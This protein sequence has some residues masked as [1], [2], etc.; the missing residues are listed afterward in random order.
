MGEE[1]VK[2]R[3]QG[4]RGFSEAGVVEKI[5]C[6]PLGNMQKSEL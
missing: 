1:R 3:S 4:R 5:N 2:N 6:Q